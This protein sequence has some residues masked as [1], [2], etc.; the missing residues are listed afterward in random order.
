MEWI[1]KIK[2]NSFINKLINEYKISDSELEISRKE[3]DTFLMNQICVKNNTITDECLQPKKGLIYN[4]QYKNN[5]IIGFY[6][7]CA[8]QK[9]VEE[10][11]KIQK[12][13]LYF[14]FDKKDLKLNIRNSV[15]WKV[16]SGD[17]YRIN[18]TKALS[19]IIKNNSNKGIYLCGSSGVG[20]T[21]L[22]KLVAN[23]ISENN[24]TIVFI[25]TPSLINKAQES[26]EDPSSGYAKLINNIKNCDVLFLDDF[27]GEQIS[28]WSRDSIIFPILN[29]R[30]NKNKIVFFSSNYPIEI[31][32]TKYNKEGGILG[33]IN[34]ERIVDRIR[35][36]AIPFII[37]GDSWRK[38]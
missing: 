12:N 19:E 24:K 33:Q 20:K 31:L 14:D 21:H 7:S 9:K 26:F 16:N 25:D 15:D 11:Y 1:D 29:S 3:I 30:I 6:L 13:Y 37:K 27:G 35:G 34:A 4:L 2:K 22:L 18:V 8:H 38:I 10:D 36:L 23:R 32:K 28:T 17:I 5:K